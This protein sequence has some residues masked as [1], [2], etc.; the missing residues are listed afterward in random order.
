[1]TG[2]LSPTTATAPLPDARL[3]VAPMMAWTD[4]HCRTLHRLFSPH[5]LLFTEMVTADAL[6]FGNGAR[7]LEH[8]PAE[9]PLVAQLGGADPER[10]ATATAQISAAGFAEINLNVGCPSD[11]VQRGRFGACLMKEPELVADCIEAM[12][13]VSQVPITVKCRLGVDDLDSDEHLHEFTA[14]LEQRGLQRLYLHARKALLK[15]LSPAQNRQIPPL[16]YER[17]YRLAEA[18]PELDI[19]LNG[20]IVDAPSA[21]EHLNHMAGVMIGRAAYQHPALLRALDDLLWPGSDTTGLSSAAD[22]RY[23]LNDWAL[24]EILT[25]YRRYMQQELNTGARLGDLCR[26]LHGVFHAR[27]GARHARRALSDHRRLAR[28]D[29]SAFDDALTAVQLNEPIAC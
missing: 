16:Q 19:V 29:L 2:S 6:I 9:Y 11:R 25:R 13:A 24:T 3:C 26:P 17:G 15:G 5:A 12:Q 4:R 1:M 21:L 18:F 23:C 7:T 28:G 20:G 14:A 10:L 8:R 27:K 22:E